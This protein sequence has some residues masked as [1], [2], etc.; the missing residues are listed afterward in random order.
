MENYSFL[1]NSVLATLI[2]GVLLTLIGNYILYNFSNEE[3]INLL[4]CDQKILDEANSRKGNNGYNGYIFSFTGYIVT[5]MGLLFLIIFSTFLSTNNKK[6]TSENLQNIIVG[7]IP[8][9][10]SLLVV[11]Y[12]IIL[13]VNYKDSL[14]AGKVSNEFFS[15]L[16][17]FSLLFLGQIATVSKYIVALNNKVDEQHSSVIY[18]LSLANILLIS[19]MNIILAFFS[20][21]G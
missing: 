5:A 16:L 10:L 1:I 13:N 14:V 6:G 11:S 2:S 21:D 20:T 15:Y 9:F 4:T 12:I 17:F 7:N 8:I 3:A 18:A 19:V